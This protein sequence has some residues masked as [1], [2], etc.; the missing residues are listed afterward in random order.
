LRDTNHLF[1]RQ[2]DLAPGITQWVES[3]I[4]WAPLVTAIAR[5]WLVAGLEDRCI[6]RDL[7]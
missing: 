7:A 2:S 4:E 1:L 3:Q 6:T 5:S